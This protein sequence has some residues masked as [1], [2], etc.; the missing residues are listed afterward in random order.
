V[1]RI[2]LLAASRASQETN[3]ELPRLVATQKISA[4]ERMSSDRLRKR[5]ASV[6]CRSFQ[7]AAGARPLRAKRR[8]AVTRDRT[9]RYC[10]RA[11]KKT[12]F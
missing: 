7:S 1:F 8:Q 9:E 3:L 2:A 12:N 5:E 6:P 4:T 11:Q 10:Y